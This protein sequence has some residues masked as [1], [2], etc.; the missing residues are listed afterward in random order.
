M[1]VLGGNIGQIHGSE[2]LADAVRARG[3]VAAGPLHRLALG[4]A[5]AMARL[6]L[7]GVSGLRLSPSTVVFGEHGEALI[8]WRVPPSGDDDLRAED[9]R[10]WAG[11]IAHAA[12]GRG[13]EPDLD[14]LPPA[15]RSVVEGCRRADAGARP[16][17][18]HLVRI[19]LGHSTTAPIA[20]VEDLLGEAEAR[21]RGPVATAP[22]ADTP[23]P[24]WRRPAS[25]A[26]LAAGAF[27]LALAA[28]SLVSGE[29]RAAASPV[30]AGGR[31]ATADPTGPAGRTAL[32]GL[33]R[34][35]VTFAQRA[36]QPEA[37]DSLTAE[38]T[39]SFDPAAPTA[40]TMRLTCGPRKA[41]ARVRLA[42]SGG[43]AD[44][45]PFDVARPAGETCVQQYALHARRNSS[46]RTILALLKAAGTAA[47]VTSG[48]GGDR[49]ITGSVPLE[50]VR[51]AETVGAYAGTIASGAVT[52]ALRVDA[53]GLPVRLRLEMS[54]GR[55][56]PLVSETEYRDW[57]AAQ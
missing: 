31:T 52:F 10:D 20:S 42:R 15:L 19:L 47:E 45:V 12:G 27:L 55:A 40:Y 13:A 39:L 50:S 11:V 3:P 48:P 46:P 36:E 26:G 8:D 16:S 32:A 33:G 38:G 35:T 14:L 34:R 41:T 25:W 54:S 23:A 24:L 53:A 56:G 21:A 51:G 9:V 57:R 29:E 4:S 44:G 37:R 28:V 2:T 49:T 22:G 30:A 1:D 5:T 18:V 43:S 17:A 6:H 7:A